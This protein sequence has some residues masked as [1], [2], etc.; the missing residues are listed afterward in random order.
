M[1][2]NHV[3]IYSGVSYLINTNYF[4]DSVNA[5]PEFADITSLAGQYRNTDLTLVTFFTDHSNI[6][7]LHPDKFIPCDPKVTYVTLD[8][9]S[10]LYKPIIKY[11]CGTYT[12]THN[13]M[14]PHCESTYVRIREC[15]PHQWSRMSKMYF[16]KY[17]HDQAMRR[18]LTRCETKTPLNVTFDKT[19]RCIPS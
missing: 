16:C 11:R 14:V 12:Y 9:S 18:G 8:D 2:Y 3:D 17:T 5:S 15:D 10:G 19:I 13:I 7:T 6:I 4:L 1:L